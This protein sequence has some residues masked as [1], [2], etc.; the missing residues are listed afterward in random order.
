MEYILHSQLQQVLK[1]S[2]DCSTKRAVV[3]LMEKI[4]DVYHWNLGKA[5]FIACWV[6][7]VSSLDSAPE[8]NRCLIQFKDYVLVPKS[9]SPYISIITQEVREQVWHQFLI[10]LMKSN[11]RKIPKNAFWAAART[12]FKAMGTWKKRIRDKNLAKLDA[13]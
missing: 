2:K 5:E 12:G 8:E 1:S 3:F 13:G 6:W 4:L 11:N 10:L 7:K 9:L